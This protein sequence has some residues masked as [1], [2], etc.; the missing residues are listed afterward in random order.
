MPDR[1]TLTQPRA[2][3]CEGVADKAFFEHLIQDRDLPK[4]DVLEV[5]G[6]DNL[7]RYL[8]GLAVAPGFKDLKGII[9]AFDNE[10]DPRASFE[11]VRDH[12]TQ[13]DVCGVPQTPMSVARHGGAPAIV[14]Y[15]VPEAGKVGNLESL[16]LESIYAHAPQMKT[17]ID[18]YCDCS[19]ARAWPIAKQAKMKVQCLISAL[20]RNE[21]NTTLRYVWGQHDC[22]ISLR[23]SS[24]DTLSKFLQN[25]DN[26]LSRP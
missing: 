7:G 6:R 24:F 14:V 21:P 9:I 4:Y 11:L 26:L 2:I 25:F 3:I 23:H 15:M 19:E 17:C 22:P 18:D 20:C 5:Q 13:S 8:H 12:L 16:C 10:D 1:V